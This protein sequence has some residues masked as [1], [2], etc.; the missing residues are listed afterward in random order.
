VVSQQNE[1]R[2]L[3]AFAELNQGRVTN[4]TG[5]AIYAVIKE[6]DNYTGPGTFTIFGSRVHAYY[7]F[8]LRQFFYEPL[9]TYDAMLEACRLNA[10]LADQ[11]IPEWA[12][13]GLTVSFEIFQSAYTAPLGRLPIP[14]SG[15]VS[16]GLHAVSV[17]GYD[18][19]GEALTFQNSWGAAWGNN[20]LGTLTREYAERYMNDAWLG[21]NARVGPTAFN[22]SRLTQAG[23]SRDFARAWMLENPRWRKRFRHRGRGHQLVNYE[24]LSIADACRV[25]VIE[26]RLGIGVRVGWAVVFHLL[27]NNQPTSVIKEL[28]VWPTSRRL[29]YG[30]ILEETAC[31]LARLRRSEQIEILFHEADALLPA[32]AAGRR[33]GD[34]QGYSWMWRSHKRPSL[35]AIGRKAL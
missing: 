11:Y 18:D 4:E 10:R 6:I 7:N 3:A 15:D 16:R 17:I 29:G 14:G 2:I 32:R 28:Y 24:A 33:F 19:Y 35:V 21:L 13:Y 26:L 25:D 27:K 31:D 8:R 9:S 34:H 20:G 23:D 12:L 5:R 22:Y 1:A 30:R